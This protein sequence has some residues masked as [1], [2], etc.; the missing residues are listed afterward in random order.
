MRTPI[1]QF[2]SVT[3]WRGFALNVGLGATSVLG[4][5]PFYL[6]PVTIICFAL[7]LLRLDAARSLSQPLRRGFWSGFSFA[8]GYFLAGLYW[9][10]SAF[11][12]RGPEFIPFMPFA[13]L[14]LCAGLSLFWAVGGLA[15]VR[16]VR[17]NTTSIWSAGIFACVFFI[18]EFARGHIFSGF[19]WNLP[20][21]IFAA[22][23]PIS[24]TAS[25][26]GIYGLT[27]LVFFLSAATALWIANPKKYLPLTLWLGVVAFCFGYGSWRLAQ[28]DIKHLEGQYV[29]GVKLR[30]VHAN[31]PQR[32]K[33]DPGKYVQTVNT[34]LQLSR[35][36][37]FE[38]VTHIIWPEGAVPGLIF[39]DPGLMSAIEQV[40]LSGTG[41][42]PVFIT[43]TLRAEPRPGKSKPAY[44]NS[45][46]AVSFKEGAPPEFTSYY[47]KQKLVPFGEFIPGGSMLEKLGLRSL[48]SAL[49]SMTPGKSGNMPHLPGLPPVS[50]QI[51][52]EIIFPGFTQKKHPKNAQKPNWILNLSNDSWYGNSSGPRQHINQARYRAI[53]QGLPVIRAT[54]GGIS[55]AIDPYGRQLNQLG[56]GEQGVI[57]TLLPQP[58]T[59]T[60]YNYTIN[61]RILLLIAFLLIGCKIVMHRAH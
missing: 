26:V 5:A 9:I 32:D 42:P 13:I 4:H 8:L 28:A 55:G 43:Q 29:D 10:G 54:S 53:E 33:F 12:A 51:C 49:E 61:Y 50:I 14:G 39:E 37:G 34:Y 46:A 31:I 15:Y 56:V 40:I 44:Y 36:V 52:Y 7:F 21:Y 22:G 6:W 30:I 16:L 38:D 25:M 27:A 24:Q 45:A 57:D 1:N 48:S 19:P 47:D 23:K 17:D 3:G 59:R 41:T 35:S 20:G 18:V 11:V 58:V 2:V 60:F